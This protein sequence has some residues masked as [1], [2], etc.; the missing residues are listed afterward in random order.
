MKFPPSVLEEIKARLPVSAVVGKRVRL[1]KAGREWKGLSPF[2]AEKTPSF[3]VNDQKGSFFDFSSGKN[4]DIFKFV[5]ETEGLSFPEAVEKLASEAGVTLPKVSFEAQ[6]QEERRKGLHEVVE[7]A[8]RF[9]EAELQSERGGL[10]R[11][12]LSGRGLEGEARQLFRLGYA[13]PDRF[14]LRDHLAAKGVGADAMMETGLLVHGEEIAVPYDRFRDRIMFPIHDARGRVIAFG[15]RAMS[16]DVPAKYLNSPETPLF[17]KGALLF[18]HHNAR[19]AAHDT[20]QVIVVEGYVDVIAMTLAGFPQVVAPLGTA[21]TEDQLSLLWRMS[22][23]PVICLD[24]DKAGRKAAGRAIDLA[25]PM[26]EPGKSLSFALLPEGQDPDDLARSGGK[27]AVAEVIGSAKPLVDMLW[28]REFEA[29]QLDTPERRAA[30]ER[31]LKEPLG[32]IRD[33]ATRRHYRREIDERLGQL[34]APPQQDRFEGRRHNGFSGGARGGRGFQRGQDRPPLSLVRPSPQLTSSPLMQRRHGE[35]PREAF[36]LLAL[37]SHP[38]LVMRCVDEIAELALDGPAAERF[39]Q[40]LLDAAIDGA[41]DQEVFGRRLEQ[42]RVAEAQ[43]ALLAVTQPAER[44]KLA[45]TA[46]P[47]SV[48]D[49]IRQALVLHHRARTLH[50]ELKAAERALAD[51]PTEANFAWMKDVKARLETI[52][53]TEANSEK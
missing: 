31:R 23:E 25:L 11:R 30:F 47:E 28:A 21:L 10:A 5:M 8:A 52:E 42:G 13:P 37:A 6:A 46:D 27:P 43:A 19:K 53:G 41:F 1:A 2:N 4:G 45:Q 29:S 38:E 14:A 36:I 18:N 40:A 33:E 39:R 32:L 7:L 12:Y 3:F 44:L 9:F 35:N 26:L 20:G 22:G 51:E 17:H 15:G 48:F 16:A 50:S 34:F 49:S 24:G